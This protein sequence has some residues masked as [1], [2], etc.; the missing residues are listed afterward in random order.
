MD[1]KAGKILDLTYL[2]EISGGNESFQGTIIR[3]FIEQFPEELQQIEVAITEGNM[4]RIK[5]LAHGIKSTVAYLGLGDKL[6]PYLH[7]MEKESATNECPSHYEEDLQELKN[8]CS[9][10]VHEAQQL[11][12]TF[13]KNSDL[14]NKN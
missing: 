3:Q 13:Q 12:E 9:K 5:S 8:V 7:R 10:A 2:N 11:I 4:Q 14:H 6:H 1:A